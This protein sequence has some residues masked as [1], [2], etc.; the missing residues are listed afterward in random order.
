MNN[1]E[2]CP[3]HYDNNTEYDED[4]GCVLFGRECGGKLVDDEE[5]GTYGCIYPQKVLRRLAHKLNKKL[6][7]LAKIESAENGIFSGFK[8][9]KFLPIN[10]G[11]VKP[12]MKGGHRHNCFKNALK[13]IRRCKACGDPIFG[14]ITERLYFLN[15]SY[16]NV[17]RGCF[18]AIEE[19]AR[20]HNYETIKEIEMMEADL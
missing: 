17:C 5:N 14:G 12:P 2:K 3:W 16:Q 1:C 10:L 11:A 18:R 20:R 9:Y 13:R 19:D 4:W 15:N 8:F 7:R 6:E